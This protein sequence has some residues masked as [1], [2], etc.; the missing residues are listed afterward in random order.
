MSSSPLRPL[1]ASD[2][3]AV[4]ALFTT[5]F[6]A[7][8]RVD[9]AEIRSWLDNSE[10]KPDNLCV[11]EVD[12]AVV[13]YGDIGIEEDEVAL[14]VAAPG[15]WELFFDWAEAVA[16]E[17]GV[18]A[19]AYFEA[20]H[21]LERLVTA[22]GYHRSRTSFTM[23]TDL[24]GPPP[25]RL[26]DGLEL[27]TYSDEHRD[28]VRVALNDAFAGSPFFHE[29]GESSFREFF[30]KGRGFDPAL[31]FLAWDDAELAGLVLAYA[32]QGSDAEL[33]WV[34][35]LG[36]R[37][38]WRRRGLGDALLRTA[39]HALHARGFRRAGLGV[40]AENPTGALRLYER[41]GMHQVARN[42]SWVLEPA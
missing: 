21:E 4:A 23:E 12:G 42:D 1:R 32:G 18:R 31:W 2:A 9:A 30:L 41:A 29:V 34:A 25:T 35:S 17:A 20:G 15:H 37:A 6:G 36:V 26:P 7:S 27:T 40:D 19:R 22:R 39:F 3:D 24:V 13:G 5:T 10:L 11:L 8:R 38:P 33:G 16:R 14:D 28:T